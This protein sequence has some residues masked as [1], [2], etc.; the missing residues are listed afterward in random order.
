MI[1]DVILPDRNWEKLGAC[2]SCHLLGNL[3]FVIF[4]PIKTER[5]C[6][7][8]VGM[9]PCGEPKNGAGVD[10]SAKVASHRHIGAQTNPDSLIKCM[11]KFRSEER[12]VGKE[13]KKRR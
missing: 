11:T 6:A 7:Y 12:R 8:R 3:T 13:R 1:C 10:P 5:K 9:M 4:W 2:F